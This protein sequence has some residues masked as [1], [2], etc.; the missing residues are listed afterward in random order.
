[1][2]GM[3]GMDLIATLRARQI[4]TPAILITTHP[5]RILRHLAECA[6]VPIVEKPLLNN[7]L[8]DQVRSA[9]TSDG[10]KGH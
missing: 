5:G 2:P 3:S 10:K 4:K 8:A 9:C 7:A 6:H 1:M